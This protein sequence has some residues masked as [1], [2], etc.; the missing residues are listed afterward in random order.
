MT[1]CPKYEVFCIK[2]SE[3]L[4]SHELSK[5]QSVL[6]AFVCLPTVLSIL[7]ISYENATGVLPFVL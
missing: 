3:N 4:F 6:S 1:F 5:Q 7:C 2:I